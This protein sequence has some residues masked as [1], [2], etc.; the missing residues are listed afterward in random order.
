MV[1]SNRSAVSSLNT[2]LAG[3]NL[4]EN[5]QNAVLAL[6]VFLKA[7]GY[8]VVQSS[9]SVT[10]DTND[11]VAS[12]ADIVSDSASNIHTWILYQAPAAVGPLF[13]ILDCNDPDA[14][15]R[16]IDWFGSPTT[17]Y[18]VDGTTAD[19]PT[20]V[21]AANEWSRINI[22]LIPTAVPATPMRIHNTRYSDGELWWGIS[23]NGTNDFETGLWIPTFVNGEASAYQYAFYYVF[24]AAGAFSLSGGLGSAT[25]WRSHHSDNTDHANADI[26]TL[27]E[28]MSNWANGQSN[29]SGAVPVNAI[30]FAHN[31]AT[32][33]RFMGRSQDVRAAPANTLAGGVEDGDGDAIR[34]LVVDD[35]WLVVQSSE[36][37]ILL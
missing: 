3:A 9:D 20:P 18:N 27:A 24:A 8:T 22:D 23:I 1:A 37:P 19:R 35:A 4:T 31:S 34:R 15:P 36:I 6:H 25:N 26:V 17:G 14:T 10:A 32:Q 11:N 28:L 30:D 5:W 29:A 13:L 16:E 2:T 12:I 33:G 21:V 7:A